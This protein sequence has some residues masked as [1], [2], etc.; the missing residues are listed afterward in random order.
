VNPLQL[1]A[2]ITCRQGPR[3]KPGCNWA[4]NHFLLLLLWL[5]LLTL[6]VLLVL[7]LIS[8]PGKG[9]IPIIIPMSR[10]TRTLLLRCTSG[11][12]VLTPGCTVTPA[13]TVRT[14]S[15]PD[16][17]ILTGLLAADIFVSLAGT[18]LNHW[19]LSGNCRIIHLD[20]LVPA[21]RGHTSGTP[22]AGMRG[23]G[24]TPRPRAGTSR[25]HNVLGCLGSW[26]RLLKGLLLLGSFRQKLVKP[27]LLLTQCFAG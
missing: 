21:A 24:L 9:G 23:R 4:G 20:L 17:H 12:L 11:A 13:G 1:E 7:L 25:R 18:L 5:T 6:P 2:R 10:L 14:C 15:L 19:L 8:R 27:G 26:V 22:G 3:S 16:R